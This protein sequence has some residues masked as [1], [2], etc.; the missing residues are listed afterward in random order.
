MIRSMTGYGRGEVVVDGLRLAAEVRS[1][2]HRFCELSARLPRTLGTF[3]HEARKIVQE[4]SVRGKINL[5]VTWGEEGEDGREPTGTLTLDERA[6]DRYMELL[7]ALQKKYGLQGA[8]DVGTFATLPN[9]FVWSEM[10]RD[11]EFY[12]GILREVVT[13]ATEDMIR[14]KETEGAALRKDLE[15]RVE[16]IRDRVAQIRERAPLKVRETAERMHERVRVLLDGNDLPE[17]RLAQEIAVMAD[18]LDATE[19]CV[20]LEAHC[21][22]FKKLLNEEATPGRKLGFL[23]QEMNREIN[24][25]GSKSA[26]VPIIEQVVDVKEE[27]ERIREQVQNIE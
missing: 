19:E 6:A 27:L 17:E 21:D 8:V 11:P 5:V 25:I 20:R 2:N 26:D 16:G 1:V 22:H 9:L 12:L 3:E 23:L 18:R 15:M 10:R 13:A 4:R 24:T 7:Q 14:M